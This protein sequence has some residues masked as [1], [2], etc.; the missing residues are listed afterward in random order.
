MV[1]VHEIKVGVNTQA[2][3]DT[4]PA[5]LTLVDYL[6]EQLDLTGTHVG[7]EH[8]S[9]GCCTVLLD[10]Q[11]IRACLLFAVQ[12]DGHAVT[13]IEGLSQQD[14]G[15]NPVQE[16]FCTAHGLQC[17][18]CTPGMIMATIALLEEDPDPTEQDVREALSGNICRCTG[19]TQ[20]L[21]AVQFAASLRNEYATKVANQ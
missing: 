6:R 13:T 8:G 12:A 11:P 19:Y 16:A 7:C 5:R 1:S 10:G 20:I 17:G 15:L 21:E 3:C 2:R 14:G 9:C 18:F 4:V